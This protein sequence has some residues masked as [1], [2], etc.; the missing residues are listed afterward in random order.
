[1]SAPARLLV[2]RPSA[3]TMTFAV[4]SPRVEPGWHAAKRAIV[5]AALHGSDVLALTSEPPVWDLDLAR[6]GG[7]QMH[8]TLD[9]WPM[10]LVWVA[11]DDALDELVASSDFGLG[12]LL[13]AAVPA[14]EPERA[15]AL[16][17][18]VRQAGV[19]GPVETDELFLDCVDDALL[20][21]HNADDSALARVTETLRT[22][23]AAAGWY[24]TGVDWDGRP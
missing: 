24:L 20:S 9:G 21:L 11:A 5:G 13:L 15:E 12:T 17:R 8:R 1:M 3:S 6:F 16:A 2:R 4:E 23:A 14:G 22:I 10:V 7:R 18:A 19:S